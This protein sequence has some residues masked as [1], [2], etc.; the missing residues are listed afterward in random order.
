MLEKYS[1]EGNSHHYY[2]IGYNVLLNQ[3]FNFARTSSRYVGGVYIDRAMIGQSGATKPNIPVELEKQ[4]EAMAAMTKY[5]FA[6]DAMD[7]AEGLYNYISPQRRGFGFFGGAPDPKP[8]G[9]VLAIQNHAIDH[10]LHHT[11]LNR[12]VNTSLYGN[13]YDIS[14]MMDDLTNGIFKTD[15]G[16]SVNTFRQNLQVSYTKKL[17]S[18]VK[19]ETSKDYMAVAQSHAIYFLKQIRKMAANGTGN[20]STKAH[21]LHLTTLIDNTLEDIK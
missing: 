6:P 9:Q 16:G 18:I 5:L 7:F 21:K 4:K 3:Y 8:H 11:T 13:E 17:I 2:F 12:I 1:I 14:T 20:V 15:I 10:L 19:G